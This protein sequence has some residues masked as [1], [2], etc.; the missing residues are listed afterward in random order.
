MVA[1]SFEMLLAGKDVHVATWDFQVASE[2][3]SGNTRL[4]ALTAHGF[5]G[6]VLIP[7]L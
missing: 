1:P 5:D 4:F 3:C 2:H 7:V 6:H